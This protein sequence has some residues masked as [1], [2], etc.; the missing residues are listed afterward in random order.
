MLRIPQGLIF[1][2]AFENCNCVIPNPFRGEE[3]H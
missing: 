2:Y 1:Q 3:P